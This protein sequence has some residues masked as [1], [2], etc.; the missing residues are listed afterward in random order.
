M[1]TGERARGFD[2]TF[3]RPGMRS[4]AFDRYHDG[5]DLDAMR[6]I[7]GG[8]SSL[9]VS[10]PER[11]TPGSAIGSCLDDGNI[12]RP[13]STPVST[14]SLSLEHVPRWVG[15]PVL[16]DFEVEARRMVG[17]RVFLCEGSL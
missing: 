11:F 3:S 8:G 12:W 6:E 4:N 14:P 1:C 16:V 10:R 17:G 5:G 7:G 9:P 15:S 13:P 2:V